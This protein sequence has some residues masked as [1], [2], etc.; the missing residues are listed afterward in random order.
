MIRARRRLIGVLFTVKHVS[1]VIRLNTFRSSVNTA[2]V[3]HF[4]SNNLPRE[5]FLYLFKNYTYISTHGH[6]KICKIQFSRV[7]S[8]DLK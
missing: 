4:I 2:F 5:L 1:F 8:H 6:D 3:T 7:T